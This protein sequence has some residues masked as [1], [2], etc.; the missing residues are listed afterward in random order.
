MPM[1]NSFVLFLTA[2]LLIGCSGTPVRSVPSDYE[3]SQGSTKG[4]LL[5]SLTYSGSYSGYSVLFRRVGAEEWSSLQIG[6]GTTLLPAGMLNWDIEKPGLRGN[7][8]A[9]E[10]ES[11]DYEFSSWSVSSGPASIRPRR[12]FSIQFRIEPR[13]A[14]YAGNFHFQRVSGLGA[15]V[16]GIDVSYND[17]YARD[18]KIIH[19]R[20][21]FVDISNTFPGVKPN[22]SRHWL[23]KD[24][25]TDLFIPVFVPVN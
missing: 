21:S 12:T 8:F 2:L 15:T 22:T 17:Q 5:A 19:D 11:G 14:S 16:T 1:K 25:E 7:V 6:S 9:I 10:L 13:V 23:G 18:V 20:Y 24:N 4:L 3:I